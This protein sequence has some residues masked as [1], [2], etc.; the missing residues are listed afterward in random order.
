[1]AASQPLNPAPTPFRNECAPTHRHAT[2]SDADDEYGGYDIADG[3]IPSNDDLTHD[4]R[5]S[6]DTID[7]AKQRV[8]TAAQVFWK[9]NPFYVLTWELLGIA[10]SICFLG[11]SV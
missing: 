6:V 3:R 1:M 7:V 5:N 8:E 4:R 2:Q 9:G 10:I 11:T